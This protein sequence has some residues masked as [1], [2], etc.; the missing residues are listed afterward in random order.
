MATIAEEWFMEGRVE[1]RVEGRAKGEVE[2]RAKGEVEGRAKGEVEGRVKGR[3]EG[4]L[5][6][7]QQGIM[8]VL[9]VRFGDVS[10]QISDA[11]F[12]IVDAGVLDDILGFAV[13]ADSLAE[14]QQK[15]G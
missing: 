6:G 3:A 1:G 10:N 12:S 5:E 15:L 11:I 14:F 13:T 4:E 7:K 2:G 9:N 8:K